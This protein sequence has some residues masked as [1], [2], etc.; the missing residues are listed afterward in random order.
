MH[1]RLWGQRRWQSTRTSQ[2][3]P[4]AERPAPDAANAAKT[5]P[6]VFTDEAI[7]AAHSSSAMAGSRL[8]RNVLAAAQIGFFA[9]LR[10]QPTFDPPRA[11]PRERRHRHRRNASL[12]RA[13]LEGK[14]W[15]VLE[16]LRTIGKDRGYGQTVKQEPERQLGDPSTPA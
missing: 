1:E 16:T 7:I 15:A 12:D 4:A 8:R 13:T 14:P 2:Q 9:D 3:S 6:R 10:N 5:H 11:T